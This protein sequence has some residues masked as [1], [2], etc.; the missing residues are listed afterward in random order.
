MNERVR[1]LT[2]ALLTLGALVGCK[3]TTVVDVYRET[4]AAAMW[5]FDVAWAKQKT[6]AAMMA[7]KKG[8]EE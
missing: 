1:P 5:E 2:I 8:A 7:E 6:P 4:P 3:S